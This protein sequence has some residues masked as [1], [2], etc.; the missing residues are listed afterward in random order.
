MGKLLIMFRFLRSLSLT[1]AHKN[2]IYFYYKCE[3]LS[4]YKNYS[5]LWQV[6]DNIGGFGGDKDRVTI[7]GESAGSASVNWLLLLPK[8]EGNQSQL[9]S[10]EWLITIIKNWKHSCT[11]STFCTQNELPQVLLPG[12]VSILWQYREFSTTSNS[13]KMKPNFSNMGFDY[14]H[15]ICFMVSLVRVGQ[16]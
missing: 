5:L 11:Y 3:G 6:R 9:A 4:F 13:P 1:H 15:Q 12:N 2:Y 16:P 8:A 7:F 14:C 10:W